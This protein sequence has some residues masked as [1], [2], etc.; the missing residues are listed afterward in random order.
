VRVLALT[1]AFPRA[2]GDHVAPFLL[3]WAVALRDAGAE[4]RVVA[5][6]APG[7]PTWQVLAGVGVRRARYAPE[8]WERLAYQGRMHRLAARPAGALQLGGLLAGLTLALRA[9]CRTFHPDVVH[10][11]WL[12]PGAVIA[13]LAHPPIPVV[14]TAH[15]TDITLT[16]RSP[17]LAAVA[18]WSLTPTARIETVSAD[19]AT[20]LTAATG[21]PVTAVNPM[22]LPSGPPGTAS[23]GHEGVLRVLGVGRLVEEKGW[24][25]LVEAVARA[26]RPGVEVEVTIAGEGPL[27]ERLLGLA[28][29]RGVTLCLPGAVVPAALPALLDGAD[30]LVQPSHREGFGLAAAHGVLAGVPVV[31]TDSGGVRDVL[32]EE[33][34]VPVG[35]V[36]AL[37]AAIR[38]VADDPAAARVRTARRAAAV[39]ALP[40][41]AAVAARTLAA[42]RA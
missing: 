36:D 40:D 28:A 5:P 27:R 13:R 30:V 35:D 24:R 19:L 42:Y 10:V 21:H 15:G 2:E 22:P 12:L 6:H 29:A 31:A 41:P 39:R 16:E 32:G 20:R 37:A 17:A 38:A 8:R 3:D 9:E 14:V 7:L 23:R 11:H 26:G 1:H 34:L 18:R 33:G 25:E 4:V